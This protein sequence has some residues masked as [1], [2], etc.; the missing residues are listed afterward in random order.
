MTKQE[1][2]RLQYLLLQYLEGRATGSE[3]Q[4]LSQMLT[5]EKH[6]SDLE[7]IMEELMTTETIMPDYKQAEWQPV[8]EALIAQ[9]AA[10]DQLPG[11]KALPDHKVVR[12]KNLLRIAAA[13]VIILALGV[14]G[15][16]LFFNTT[17]KQVEVAQVTPEVKA[18]ESNRAVIILANGQKIY[19]DSAV[20]G[21]LALQSNVKL[22]KL[23]NGKIVYS[24]EGGAQTGTLQYN[25]LSNPRGSR[26]IDMALADGSHIWLNAGSSVTY[27]VAFI[28][29]E[30]K[31]SIT[32][33]AYFEIAKN[34]AMPFT[35]NINNK[36]E[37]M[38]LGT[39]FNVNAYENESSINTTLLEGA[40]LVRAA[41]QTQLLAPGQ[42]AQVDD[43]QKI[44]LMKK[45]DLNQAIAWK[46][47][48]FDFNGMSVQ[49]VM[50]QLERWYDIDVVYEKSVP[51]IEFGGKITQN[52]SLKGLLIGLEK[53]ELHFRLEGRKLI[54][55]P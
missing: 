48:L 3:R 41:G 35:L 23:E 4:R 27:P 25:T 42:Q 29:K 11:T 13:A 55:L 24:H 33:E 49:E 6:N 10:S 15:Y 5:E 51:D 43:A 22:V 16:L 32:G 7:D 46:N 40:V 47:G 12:M 34:A 19:L 37:V 14:T 2:E 52:V 1:K 50:R 21:Q 9:N 17:K 36:A 20:N 53:S 31:V 28:G 18:P 44:K 45:V 39:H 26:V 8:I 54:V 30:R 38:V